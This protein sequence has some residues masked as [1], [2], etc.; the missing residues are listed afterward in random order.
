MYPE[1]GWGEEQ[2]PQLCG[3]QRPLD[4]PGSRDWALLRLLLAATGHPLEAQ[5]APPTQ[6]ARPNQSGWLLEP[7]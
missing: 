1:Q 2:P 5:L 4:A 3:K 6:T 7:H